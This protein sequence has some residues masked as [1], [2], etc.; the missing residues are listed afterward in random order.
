MAWRQIGNKP[1]HEPMLIR[2]TKKHIY[3]VLGGDE[4][5]LF[6]SAAGPLSGYNKYNLNLILKSCFYT[7]NFQLS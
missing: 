7:N 4:L 1:L 2:V 3:V 6:S 5:K